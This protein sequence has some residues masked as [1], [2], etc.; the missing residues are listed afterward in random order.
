MTGAGAWRSLAGAHFLGLVATECPLPS[1]A[2]LGAGRTARTAAPELLLSDALFAVGAHSV[3]ACQVRVSCWA[4]IIFGVQFWRQLPPFMCCFPV[5][6]DVLPSF[7]PFHLGNHRPPLSHLAP[8]LQLLSSAFIVG[9]PRCLGRAS[10]SPPCRPERRPLPCGEPVPECLCASQ[11]ASGS[12]EDSAEAKGAGPCPAGP[13]SRRQSPGV[14]RRQLP[15]W[16]RAWEWC[17][18][19]T[20][21]CR[22]EPSAVPGAR[23]QVPGVQ[24]RRP[25]W[26]PLVP[27]FLG[28]RPWACGP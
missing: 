27:G 10:P 1:A 19:L 14:E 24:A 17:L 4:V 22:G 7:D 13:R 23:L 2:V 16:A 25:P 8:S 26:P 12:Q 18:R 11:C 21:S 9:T 20:R 3:G 6:R 28:G 15:G 5:H